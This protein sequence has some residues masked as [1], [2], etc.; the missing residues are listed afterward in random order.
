VS[1]QRTRNEFSTD[2]S[3]VTTEGTERERGEIF[4]NEKHR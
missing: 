3:E 4:Y 2:E 1:G